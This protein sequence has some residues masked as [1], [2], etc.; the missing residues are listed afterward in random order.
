MARYVESACRICRRESK[1]L[2]LKGT[3]CASDRCALERRNYIPGEH[4][5]KHSKLSDYAV[6]LREKQQ[7][8]RMYGILERQF[9]NYYEKATQRRGITGVALL[10]LLEARLDNMVYRMGFA[11]SHAAARQ[12]VTHGHFLVNSRKVNIPSYQCKAGQVIEVR[13][14]SRKTAI[15]LS[16][17]KDAQKRG[18]P[19]WVSLDAVNFRGTIN[20]LPTREQMDLPVQEQ[21]IVELYSK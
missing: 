21:L 14:K 3:R 1:K 5:Q 13:E 6:R 9:R 7:V 19:A 18:L 17:V 4:G 16:S 12:L 2:F 20:A 11:P 8:R 15:I 10:T